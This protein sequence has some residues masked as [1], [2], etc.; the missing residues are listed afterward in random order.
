MN[1]DQDLKAMLGDERYKIMIDGQTELPFSGQYLDNHQP[2]V[3]SCYRCKTAL[4]SSDTKF[5][6]G[7]GWPSFYKPIDDKLIKYIDDDSYG[8]HRIEVVCATCS[9]HLGHVFDDAVNQPTQQR[10]CLNSLAL[11]FKKDK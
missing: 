4:F 6:S 3:Y 1:N 7:S 10:Y 2:G 11:D 9:S 8:M 5:E